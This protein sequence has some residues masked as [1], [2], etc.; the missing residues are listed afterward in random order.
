MDD[1][2]AHAVLPAHTKA[3]PPSTVVIFGASGDLTKRLLM[4][5]LYNLANDQALDDKFQIIGVDLVKNDDAGYQKYLTD[6]MNSLIAEGGGEF[7]ATELEE[8]PWNWL[9]QRVRYLSGDFG[10]VGTFNDLKDMIDAR[11]EETGSG[12]AVFYLAVA[13]RFF[14]VVAEQLGA[15]G[16]LDETDH[17]FRR[18]VV[19]KPFG[20]DLASAKALNA[21]LLKVASEKQ[22]FRIDHFLGKETVQNIMVLRFANGLFEPT[23]SRDHID[24]VEITAAETVGVEKRGRFYEVTGA[25]RDMV[26]N[27]MFQLLAMIAMEPPNSFDADAIRTEKAKVIEAIRDLSPEEAVK[28]AV[29]GQ[30]T[31]GMVRGQ[32]VN[33]YRHEPDVDAH[34]NTETY[35]AMKFL[36]DNWRWSGVPFFVRTGKS[37]GTRRTEIVVQFKRA[38]GVLFRHTTGEVEPNMMVFRI[39]PNEGV[40]IRFAAKVPGREVQISE[41]NMDFRYSDYFKS[42]P[43][44]GYETL[45]YDVLTGDQTLFQRADNIEAGWKAVQPILDGWARNEGPLEFYEA[46]SNGPEGSDELL[47]R[48]DCKWLP[49]E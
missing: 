20:T 13:P 28:N 5:A 27:H 4:P 42:E 35:V 23:W 47:E 17:G 26:P 34:S 29:R 21:Q 33:A 44:T 48:D 36:I 11:T 10:N 25:L 30:Y 3:A 24:H 7:A 22:I 14:G 46:G 12:N 9:T 43:S 6:S 15:A 8:K 37:M 39:Q 18:I 1:K 2:P 45:I 41:V 49:L 40:S 32:P 31:A 16:L 38:P 19:E